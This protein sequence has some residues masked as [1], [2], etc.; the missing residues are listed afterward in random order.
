MI[1]DADQ[2]ITFQRATA[3]PDGIGG[4]TLVWANLSSVPT[5]WAKVTPRVG[6]ESMGEGRMNATLTATFTVRYRSDV[7][8]LDRILWRGEAWNIRRI[9]RK[10][11]RNLWLDI[12][13]ERGVA[14]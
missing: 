6:K 4:Q 10:S 11:G 7:T 9:L 14:S 12:D 13:A 2:R 3:T 8:E 5:V 1:G